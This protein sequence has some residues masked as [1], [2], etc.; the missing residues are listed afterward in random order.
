M[1]SR[2]KTFLAFIRTCLTNNNRDYTRAPK[3]CYFV[4]VVTSFFS[5]DNNSIIVTGNIE[6]IR[7]IS[8]NLKTWHMCYLH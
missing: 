1:I 3:A 4:T 6:M 8:L 5:F 7:Q 2:K